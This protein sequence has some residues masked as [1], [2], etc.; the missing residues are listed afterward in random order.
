M[1]KHKEEIAPIDEIT[2]NSYRKEIDLID[3]QII[4]LLAER[5]E[6]SKKIW[7]YKQEN[8]MTA[9][10]PERWQELLINRKEKA[11]ELKLSP[12]FIED[13]WNCIHEESLE[14]QK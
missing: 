12:H 5:A 3:E 11:E 6:V 8:N 14:I 10:Q 1:S 13:L 9:H 2:I 7:T 4:K